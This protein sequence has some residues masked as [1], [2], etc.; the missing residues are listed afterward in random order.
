MDQTRHDEETPLLEE[1]R[2][3]EPQSDPPQKPEPRKRS[4]YFWRVFWVLVAATV[5]AVFIKG[6]VDA[7][8]DV[9]VSTIKQITYDSLQR[10]GSLMP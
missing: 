9:D 3:G 4:W 10:F 7:G 1:E 5:L 8:G 2:G 6:W